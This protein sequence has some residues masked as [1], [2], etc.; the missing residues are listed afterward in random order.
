M[1][2]DTPWLPLEDLVED[3]IDRRG[4][5]PLK[6]G[7]LFTSSGH[8]VISAKLLKGGRIDLGADEPR[9]V[10]S[11]VYAKWMKGS[12]L[13][14]DVLMTSE[15]PLG[16]LAFIN[17]ELDWCLGQRLFAIRPKK[18]R[19][20]GCFAYYALQTRQVRED[21]FGRS[22]GTTVQG[23]RQSELRRV[24]LPVPDLTL[25]VAAAS[26]LKA[27][28]DR[29]ALLRETNAT[30][31]AIAQA[32]FKSWFVDF[33]PVRAKQQ[34]LA[35]AGMDEATAALFAGNIEAWNE[36]VLR[37]IAADLINGRKLLIGDGYRA[38]NN[39]LGLPG[40]SF[41]RAGDL[42]AGQ[43][44]PTK[45]F[46]AKPALNAAAGKMAKAGDT[47]FT[48]KGTIGRFAF[49]DEGSGDAV[50]SPQ[51]CF[52]RSLDRDIIE[53]AY[54]H[55]WM[56]SAAFME[57]VKAVCGQAA[58]ME[59][60]SLSDQRGMR[61]DLPPIA[62]QRRFAELADSL[63]RRISCNRATAMLLASL[64]D[65]LLPRLISGQLRLPDADRFKASPA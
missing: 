21:L 9:Y 7:G 54:L 16:E 57:Q 32:L 55:Y 50:Y 41:V 20:D 65:T 31:E 27:L 6:L 1:S 61:L 43:I 63:L 11:D 35:P 34:G 39:E 33:D 45:D 58:I 56:K 53:P 64:R 14:G 10:N 40:V 4:L 13:P 60:V 37:P 15:A 19:L 3:I 29:I 23:I 5:T 8:R 22:T 17:S 62:I 52:W 38:K 36:C 48:S 24:R 26:V 51:V 59:Y 18:D 25:Q 2:S 49:V 28:D 42:D 44:T 46:L 47:A 12:L 30:L